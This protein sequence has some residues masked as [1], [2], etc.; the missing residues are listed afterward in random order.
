MGNTN[1]SCMHAIDHWT[2]FNF[3]FPLQSKEAEFVAE[4]FRT[5]I[6]PYFGIP[7]IF[8]TDNG[9]EFFANSIIENLI[10]SWQSDIQIIHG[11][12]RH[13]QTQGVIKRAHRTLEQ[14]LATQISSTDTSWTKKLPDVVCKLNLAKSC[15]Y[16]S[17]NFRYVAINCSIIICL[18][19][20]Y[21]QK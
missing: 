13:P 2:K 4:I 5:Y 8:H 16:N 9:R 21:A 14:K 6:F 12:P 15:T 11:R 20:M 19:L 1:G 10:E 7:K 18:Y 17:K 3:A